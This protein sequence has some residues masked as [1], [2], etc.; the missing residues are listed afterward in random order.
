LDA[1]DETHLECE[2]GN[3]E[4]FPPDLRRL[5]NTYI[6]GVVAPNIVAFKTSNSLLNGF[7]YRQTQSQLS[8]H[9][10]RASEQL[11][12]LSPESG[13]SV[14]TRFCFHFVFGYVKLLL[15]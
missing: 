15:K 11:C 14:L 2:I 8:S 5:E 10:I 3:F 4:S 7:L 1:V 9:T 12:L 13:M 6:I